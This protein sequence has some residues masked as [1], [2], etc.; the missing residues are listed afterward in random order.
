MGIQ[1]LRGVTYPYPSLKARKSVKI[2]GADIAPC[3]TPRAG[4]A[5][6]VQGGHTPL[7]RTSHAKVITW[8]I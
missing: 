3:S 5:A 1:A 7:L 8:C 2:T 4:Y 6:K